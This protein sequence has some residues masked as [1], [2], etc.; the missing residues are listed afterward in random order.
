MKRGVAAKVRPTMRRT[1]RTLGGRRILI[2]GFGRG[3]PAF[4][5]IVGGTEAPSCVW[6]SQ[7]ELRRLIE[8]ARKILK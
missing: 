2:E 7:R 1:L 4:V 6:L 3:A 5:A 8:V